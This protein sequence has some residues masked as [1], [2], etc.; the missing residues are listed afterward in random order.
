MTL[1]VRAATNRDRQAIQAVHVEAFP[2]GEGATVAKLAADLLEEDTTPET[3][4]LVAG[5]DGVIVGHA[6]FSPVFIAD[7]EEF[8]G[9]I[10]SPLAVKASSQK[11]GIGRALIEDGLRRLSENGVEVVF[12]YGDPEYYGRFGFSAEAASVYNAPYPLQYP[13]GWQAVLLDEPKP[14][15]SP[16][17]I[18][19]V[20]SLSDPGLW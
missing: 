12:V 2:E 9:Y 1:N 6:A 20:D 8:K 5:R 18:I 17:T 10:L 4:S 16:V 15:E 13:F 11:G 14:A 3:L 7:N 19:C